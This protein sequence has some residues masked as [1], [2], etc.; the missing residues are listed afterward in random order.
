MITIERLPDELWLEVFSYIPYLDLFR[1][2]SNLNQRINGIL[3]SKR[4]KLRLRTK[5]SYQK[6]KI[7][8]ETLPEYIIG[9]SIEYYN[10]DIDLSPF[11][12]LLSLHIGHA[13]DQQLTLIQSN[14]FKYLNQLNIVVFPKDYQL[15]NILF[16]QNQ[17]N[18]LTTCWFPNFDLY[19]QHNESYQPCLTLRSLR[20]NY[21]HKNTFFKLLNFLPNLISFESA[22]VSIPSSNKPIPVPSVEHFNLIRLKIALRVNASLLDLKS[23]LLNVP[24]LEQFYLNIDKPDILEDKL[25]LL[26]LLATLLESRLPHMKKCD[27]KMNIFSTNLKINLDDLKQISPLFTHVNVQSP[28]S[29]AIP[30]STWYQNLLSKIKFSR[31]S[32]T[33]Q[34]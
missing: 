4:I 32:L 14:Y 8:L 16:N 1:A 22:L 12:N 15:G 27:I 19:F 24:C 9:L 17:F 30:L 29:Y 7:L 21:C 3:R 33:I 26:V 20:L 18:Y 28:E 11:K 25:D 13:T 10:Q 5:L 6:S 23:M 2:F 31:L 34:Q